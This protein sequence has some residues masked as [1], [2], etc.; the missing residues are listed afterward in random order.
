M[1]SEKLVG[2]SRRKRLEN[3]EKGE[4]LRGFLY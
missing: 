2:E 4:K 3:E 1:R